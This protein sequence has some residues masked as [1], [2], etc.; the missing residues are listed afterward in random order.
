MASDRLY[1]LAFAYR[2]TKL[3]EKIKDSQIFAVKLSDGRI[4]YL[5]VMGFGG[6]YRAIGL[7]IG[8]ER[9]NSLCTIAKVNSY[10]IDELDNEEYYMSQ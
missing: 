3:W 1:E 2:K 8:E 9:W 4:G 7:Y 6:E 10:L 5:S